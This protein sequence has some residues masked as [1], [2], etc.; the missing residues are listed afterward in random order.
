MRSPFAHRFDRAAPFRNDGGVLIRDFSGVG[1][2][3]FKGAGTTAWLSSTIE[4]LPDRPNR[5][6]ALSDGTLVARLGNEEYLVLDR[7]DAAS[8]VSADLEFAWQFESAQGARRIG[9][10][11]PRADSHS[12]LR[13][14]GSCV[15]RMMAKICAVDL[16]DGKFKPG[17]VAQTLV[18]QIG[19]VLIRQTGRGNA[20]LHMLTDF[21]SADYLWDVLE[22][23]AAEFGGGFVQAER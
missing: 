9:Y 2:T 1:R 17:E 11:L 8:S 5:A 18:A 3:G 14:E 4:F 12:W 20:G 10:L 16:R 15:D 13:L 7:Y 21:A 22:D 6:V 19:A 23:A